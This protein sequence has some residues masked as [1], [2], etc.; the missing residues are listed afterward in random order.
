MFKLEELKKDLLIFSGFCRRNYILFFIL[1]FILMF[2]TSSFIINKPIKY[3][4]ITL[5][6]PGFVVSVNN[7]ASEQVKYPL[8]SLDDV[9]NKI[10]KI[11]IPAVIEKAYECKSL[12]VSKQKRSSLLILTSISSEENKKFC[13]DNHNRVLDQI[14]NIQKKL[15][16]P[17]ESN[18][19]AINLGSI[20]ES[21]AYVVGKKSKKEAGLSKTTL[22]IFFTIVNFLFCLFVVC[23]KDN[24]I[25]RY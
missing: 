17:I 19:L 3:E 8:E 13:V 14:K 21:T 23:I 15:I 22:I 7:T 25:K 20:Q 16:L 1:Y 2:T 11:I 5:L 4:Y 9:F 6:E 10:R 24:I 18:E 12:S